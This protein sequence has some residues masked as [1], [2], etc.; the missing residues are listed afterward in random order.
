ESP[1]GFVLL[2]QFGSMKAMS[3]GVLPIGLGQ[4]GGGMTVSVSS[5]GF[6]DGSDTLGRSFSALGL[7]VDDRLVSPSATRD[8]TVTVEFYGGKG[9]FHLE[10]NTSSGVKVSK[11]LG[12]G[13]GW[14]TATITIS[15][16]KLDGSLAG[17]ADLRLVADSGSPVVQLV[18]VIR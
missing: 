2:G 6:T 11:S 4:T 10:A 7:A 13:S 16:A 3:R 8:V 14:Q 9:T 1:D 18:R 15:G 5:I 17:G 12:S